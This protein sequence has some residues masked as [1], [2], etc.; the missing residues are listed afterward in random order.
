MPRKWKTFKNSRWRFYIVQALKLK[1][2]SPHETSGKKKRYV[3]TTKWDASGFFRQFSLVYSW[4]FFFLLLICLHFSM[5]T[6]TL[7]HASGY[8]LAEGNSF[9]S[10]LHSC[11]SVF[12]KEQ[13][14]KQS[15]TL[16]PEGGLL[17]KW[18]KIVDILNNLFHFRLQFRKISKYRILKMA[19]SWLARQ[20]NLSVRLM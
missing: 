2:I 19:G 16:Q 12:P 13:C 10:Q 14:G 6:W 18:C 5:I 3:K 1:C 9:A 7:S 17:Y 4:L 8:A 11:A 15:G 20:Q